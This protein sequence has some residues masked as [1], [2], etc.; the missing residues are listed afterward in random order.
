MKTVDTRGSV[1]PTVS[2]F[3]LLPARL[4]TGDRIAE[5]LREVFPGLDWDTRS[6]TGL[7]D[8][9]ASAAESRPDVYVVFREDLPA[10]EP[11]EAALADGFGAV[12]G[13]EVVEMRPGGSAGALVSRRW[14]IASRAA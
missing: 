12:A 11:A 1:A 4:L 13:D 8:L 10:G 3:Y 6:R 14:R 2:T 9:V 5:T 7:A